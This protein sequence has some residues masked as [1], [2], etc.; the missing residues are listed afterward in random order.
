MIGLVSS[1]R[2]VGRADELRRLEDGLAAAGGGQASAF[3]IAGEAGVGK[4]R[5]VEELVTR[6]TQEGAVGLIGGC[7]DVEEGRL[8]FAPFIEALRTYVRELDRAGRAELTDA[9][10]EELARIVPELRDSGEEPTVEG[11]PVQGRMF[12]LMLGLLGHLSQ[13]APLVLALEDLHWSDRSTRDL[14]AYVVRNLRSERVLLVATYRSDELYR[15]H[16]LRPFLAELERTRRL[17]RLELH[18][19]DHHEVTEIISEILGS[20]AD[21][22]LTESVFT[23]AQGNAFFTEELVAAGAGGAEIPHTLSD[24]LLARVDRRPPEVQ[25]IL[26]VVAA[27]GRGVSD[28]LLESVSAVPEEE[29]LRALREAVTHH[30]LLSDSSGSYVFRHE[31]LREVV[32]EEMLAEERVRLHAAYGAALGAHPELASDAETVAGDLARHWLA[33]HDLPRALSAAV[34]AGAVAETRS[35]FAEAQTHYE[36]A[37]ELWD[38][39]PD[40]DQLAGVGRVGL[41]RRAA[42]VANLAGEHARAAALVRGALGHVDAARDPTHAGVLWERLGRFL[43][44]AGDSET[45]LQAYEQAVRLVP[46]DPPSPERARVLA[47]RGQA[48]MLLARHDESRRCCEE[49]IA[50]ARLVRARA[51]EGHA[52]NTLGC[53]LAYLG[54]AGSA[55]AHLRQARAIAEEVGD[56]DDLFRA[57]LNLS[58]LLGGPLNRLEEALAL[59]LEGAERSQ[60]VGMAG[61]YGVSLQCNAAACLLA[62]GRLEQAGEVLAAAGARNPT[63]MAAIDLHRCRARLELA[64]GSFDDVVVQLRAA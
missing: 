53:D 52:L 11:A 28:R 51:Q 25:A 32:Y 44:A 4:T 8:P 42:E 18:P 21:A 12:E 10:V 22:A 58:D 15:G 50:I 26:R 56:L 59:A 16:P 60:A 40:A 35:G 41:A 61:D 33:A 27:G 19:F 37:L 54:D 43:W 29:R 1:P 30:L 17:Q 20:A 38:R 2:F 64:R 14:L 13:R 39:V 24:I 36:R 57:Y 63:E 46:A 5:L 34:R 9:G 23:R 47:A 45:A 7:L 48:L 6:A 55:V 49:A 31:L 3:L 62:L